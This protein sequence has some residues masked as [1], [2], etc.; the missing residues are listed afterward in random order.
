MSVQ[1]PPKL[2]K[3]AIQTLLRNEALAM[4]SLEELPHVLYPAVFEEAFAGRHTKLI[5]AMVAAWPYRSL[6]VG[7]FMKEPNVENLQ[8]VLDGV[9]VRLKRE[10]YPG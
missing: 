5:K 4:S 7:S 6:P 2:Q 1:T 10:F 9:D 8:A 3:L